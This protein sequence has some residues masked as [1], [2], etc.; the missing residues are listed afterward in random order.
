MAKMVKGE[1]ET[2]VE[3]ELRQRSEGGKSMQDEEHSA[4]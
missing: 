4:H 3:M 2:L 1:G